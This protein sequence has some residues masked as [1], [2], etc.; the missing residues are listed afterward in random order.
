MRV[1]LLALAL[2]V[3]DIV[4]FMP[5]ATATAAT[6]AAAATSA[7]ADDRPTYRVKKRRPLPPTVKPKKLKKRKPTAVK[8]QNYKLGPYVGVGGLAHVVG[9]DNSTDLTRFIESGGGVGMAFG[10]RFLP[11]LALELGFAISMH[12]TDEAV[13]TGY[14]SGTLFGITLDGLLYPLPKAEGFDPYFQLGL[15]GYSFMEKRMGARELS[16]GG[17]HIGGGSEF[18]LA[19]DYS[20]DVKVLYKGLSMDNSTEWYPPTESVYLNVWMFQAGIKILFN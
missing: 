1:M 2:L 4:P 16:G 18:R 12:S 11:V 14:R 15:G 19:K 3:T 10:T 17:F 6:S 7:S 5:T 9:E 13:N 8:K 20:I